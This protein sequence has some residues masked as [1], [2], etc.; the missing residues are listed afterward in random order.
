MKASQRT[1]WIPAPPNNR[2][3]GRK[4]SAIAV[5]LASI[6]LLGALEFTSLKCAN[7]RDRPAQADPE[8]SQA[9]PNG[10]AE[11]L[12]DVSASP[13]GESIPQSVQAAQV[14]AQEDPEPKAEWLLA[15]IP[16][17]SPAIGSGLEWAVARVFPLSLQDSKSPTSIAGV[18]GLFTNNGSR[19][20]AVGGQLHFNKDKYRLTSFIGKASINADIYG[21]GR[22]NGDRGLYLP[23]KTSGSGLLGQFLFRIAKGVYL[24]PRSQYRNLGLSIDWEKL[25]Y[26][27][28][29]SN[30]PEDIKDLIDQ[31]RENLFHQKTFTIGP[32]FEWDTRD[33][34]YYPNRGFLLEYYTDFSALWIGRKL[35][36]QYTKV[37]FNKYN[38][39][40]EHQ[41][42]AF[43][44]VGCTA[45]GDRVPIYDLCLFGA[46]N[47][48]RGYSAGRY[49]DRRMFATQA[50]YRFFL[51]AK[52]FLG[53]FG[54]VGFAGFGAVSPAF[55]DIGFSDLLPAGGGGVRFRMTKQNPISFRVDVGYGKVG[56]TLN[57]GIAEAF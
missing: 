56:H 3:R 26:S 11:D 55:T 16:M 54:V 6:C 15:P 49:Q 35:T 2:G 53:R 52:G 37:S 18:G 47:D 19:A 23:L 51:P 10:Q 13:A 39:L 50:E 43:R 28:I 8:V 41:V 14:Q 34:S 24:G 22:D 31:V 32:K 57:I 4:S 38:S 1:S 7:G 17:S 42:I 29:G 9:I 30:L 46:S 5:I 12:K 25:G 36:Y 21:I 45:T 33:N 20:I 48:L 27:D 40:S 44:G